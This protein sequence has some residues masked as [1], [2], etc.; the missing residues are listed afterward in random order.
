MWMSH[1]K[2]EV[3]RSLRISKTRW[4]S[5]NL[6]TKLEVERS[7]RIRRRRRSS[8]SENL[9]NERFRVTFN[10]STNLK[11]ERFR[12]TFNVSTNL[13]NERRFRVQ[14]ER[15]GRFSIENEYEI[16]REWAWRLNLSVK[17]NEWE[18]WRE[19]WRNE[20]YW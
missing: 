6:R 5:A 8:V 18:Q 14:S 2:L 3:E 13:K 19:Q 7:L 20:W 15:F 17:S 10:V 12:V 16:D 11:N 1:L 4:S 9:K